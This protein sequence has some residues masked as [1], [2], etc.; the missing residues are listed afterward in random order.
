MLMGVFKVIVNKLYF[1]SFDITF[2]KNIKSY[3]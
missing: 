1:K 2:I 3:Q